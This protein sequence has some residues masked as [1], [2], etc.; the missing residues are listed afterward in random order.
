MRILRIV[1]DWPQPWSGLAPAPYELTRSQVELGHTFD[2]F[3]GRWLSKPFERLPGVE[4]HPFVREPFPGSIFFTTAPFMFLYYF[5]WKDK[6]GVD[7]IHSHGHFGI[8]VYAYRVFLNRFFKN[9]P[10]LKIPL[11]VHFHN[12]F[13]GRQKKLEDAGQ[14]PKFFSKYV[15]WPLGIWSD[16]LAIKTGAAY[17]FVSEELKKEAIEYYGADPQKCFVVESGVDPKLFVSVNEQERHSTK[18]D[19][20]MDY[21]DKVILNLG[22]QVQRKNIHLLIEALEFLPPY[23]KLLLVGPSDIKYGI[24]LDTLISVKRLH[25]RVVRA[26]ETSYPQTPIAYQMADIFVLP[27]SFEGFPKVVLE[28]LSC[29]VP[30]LVSGFK[31][32]DDLRGIYYLADLTPQTIAQSILNIV[33]KKEPVDRDVVAVKYSWRVRALQVEK[34]YEYVTGQNQK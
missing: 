2:I 1:Y 11:V 5:F 8:W 33:S 16:K 29:G 10:E 13:A 7:L 25:N 14:E 12:T 32:G 6:A 24:E 31:A 15:S 20:G 19:M 27:S 17:I 26:D 4:F 34:V 9:S 28:A 18:R 3:C 30:A 21:D 23:F 22:K